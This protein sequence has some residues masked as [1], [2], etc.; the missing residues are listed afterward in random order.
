M[1]LRLHVRTNQVFPRTLDVEVAS[2]DLTNSL[3]AEW[4]VITPNEWKKAHTTKGLVKSNEKAT[5]TIKRDEKK[6]HR[7]VCKTPTS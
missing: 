1:K 3:V 2:L 7:R 4:T 6:D 5:I